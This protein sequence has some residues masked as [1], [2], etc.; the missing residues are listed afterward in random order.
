MTPCRVLT[1]PP[2][3]EGI[4]RNAQSLQ[5]ITSRA[6]DKFDNYMNQLNTVRERDESFEQRSAELLRDMRQESRDMASLLNGLAT[7]IQGLSGPE[8]APAN[9]SL[10]EIRSLMASL[11]EQVRT[12][13]DTL[14][15][16]A[17]EA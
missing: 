17:E 10:E 5:E 12:V 7:K 11:N 3:A 6:L 14:T 1:S 16:L 15:R 13:S 8:D 9:K 4:V 2:T